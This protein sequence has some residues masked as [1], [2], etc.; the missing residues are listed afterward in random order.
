M[1]AEATLVGPPVDVRAGRYDSEIGAVP[2]S[3]IGKLR[4]SP[5]RRRRGPPGADPAESSPT[6]RGCPRPSVI[7]AL[8]IRPP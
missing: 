1:V 6:L 8:H 4:W 2:A 5:W 3:Q 7:D